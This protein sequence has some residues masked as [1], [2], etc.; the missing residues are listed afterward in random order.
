MASMSLVAGAFARVLRGDD[1]QLK[2]DRWPSTLPAVVGWT[3]Y[4]YLRTARCRARGGS[5]RAAPDDEPETNPVKTGHF[6]VCRSL[7][8]STHRCQ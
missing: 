1:P 8:I 2:G 5:L 4:Q 3:V 7:N 6:E